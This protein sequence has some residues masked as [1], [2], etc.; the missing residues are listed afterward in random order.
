MLTFRIPAK[1]NIKRDLLME[2]PLLNQGPLPS[3]SSIIPEE[4]IEAALK[5]VLS[6]NRAELTELLSKNTTF[7]WDNLMAPLEDIGDRLSKTWAPIGH[8]HGVAE[9]ESLRA[10]YNAC[11]PL[12]TEYHTEI[13][14]NE[15][16]FKAIQSIAD[17]P[18]Y[19]KLNTAQR[20]VIDNELRDFKLTGVSLPAAAKARLGDMQK[21]LSKLT[22]QFAE[23][24]LDAT[25]AWTLHVTDSNAMSG[26]PE[27]DLKIAEQTAQQQGKEGWVLTLEY[28]CYAAVM[29]YL[30]SR[31]LRWLMYEAYS[32]RASD[33]GPSAGRFNNTPIMEEILQ[34]RHEMATLL[35][36]QNYAEFSLAIKMAKTPKRVL[37]FLY[38]LVT[39]S[40]PAAEK[41][42][43]ELV[44]FAKTKGHIQTL[45]TWDIAFYS[46]KLRQQKYAISQEELKP[47]FP[48]QKVLDGIFTVVNKL[49]GITITEKPNVDTWHPQVNFFEIH[50]QNNELRGCFYTDLYARA[51]KR[52]GAWM[53]ECRMRRRLKD[54]SIQ[55]PVAFLTCN[56]TRP[57]G[58]KPALL[59]QDEVETLFHE[60]GHCLHHLLT[61]IDYS[62][63][64]GINGVAWD[65][66]EFPSQIMEH[67]CWEKETMSLISS[68]VETGEHLP[69]MLY[70]KLLAAKNFQSGMQM[71]RQLEF[72]LFDFRIHLEYDPAKGARIQEI[73][74]DVRHNVAVI[75]Y[76]KFNRFQNSFSHIFAGSY[77]AGYYSYKWAEVLSSDAYSLFEETGVFNPQTG[78]NYL[79]NILEKGGVRDPMASFVAF[80][81]REPHIDALLRHSGLATE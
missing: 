62:A 36:F 37:D 47:Y 55:T 20:K 7:T 45:E 31:E 71:L 48:V 81:G 43:Q 17:G 3:F 66:V 26:L 54:G 65:A 75:H 8:L 60:F 59:S 16:L 51:Q 25:H 67:W 74:D 15:S 52:D 70:N 6:N 33:Q 14:Q 4:H 30:D 35:G 2:N 73:L 53:D 9:T 11:L 38:D 64:S 23:N 80:R 40:K 39:R 18:E 58:N 24:A 13:M 5:Q 68:H 79:E 1:I 12:L 78:K 27:Q 49:Y 56:F 32:T 57:I 22:T 19:E 28:P 77:C 42:M 63:I 41:E 76:P 69:D 44:E 10:A 50:D 34:L 72:S 21:Q 46:E 61:K 29:K